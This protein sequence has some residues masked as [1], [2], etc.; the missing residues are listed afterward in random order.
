MSNLSE[1]LAT[2]FLK[3]T[4]LIGGT[5]SAGTADTFR[6]IC[7][8]SK[9]NMRDVIGKEYDNYNL[10]NLVLSSVSSG[11]QTN[12]PGAT[13]EDRKLMVYM[14][15]LSWLNQTYDTAKKSRTNSAL[16]G[17]VYFDTG[18]GTST[19]GVIME[20]PCT[21]IKADMTTDITITL[22]RNLDGASPTNGDRAYSFNYLFKI[23]GIRD[24]SLSHDK[25][26]IQSN[27]FI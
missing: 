9:I 14:S 3:S 6:K 7:Q 25:L 27:S 5:N 20:S 4:D 26:N 13:T 15:G 17:H 12:L 8:W 16:V 18:Q 19:N 10:F 21:F 11:L 2:L 23:Y 22:Y 1:P 24:D